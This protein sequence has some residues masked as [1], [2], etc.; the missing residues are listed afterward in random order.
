MSPTLLN[1]Y[2][3]SVL[4]EW[5]KKCRKMGTP[6]TD[7]TLY[8]L[9]FADDQVLI[10]QDEDDMIYMIKKLIEE[11]ELWGMKV[12]MKKTEYLNLNGNKNDLYIEEMN[13]NIKRTEEFKFLG[14]IIHESGNPKNDIN[15]KIMMAKKSIG[16]LNGIL[17]NKN[18]QLR[19]I[20]NNISCNSREYTNL[21]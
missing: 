11:Y 7:N 15:H 4:N 21:W 10:A 16:A 13:I 9:N 3:E 1:I 5:K 19:V 17:W 18:T 14:S 12:Y 2:L 8:S 6:I 20:K